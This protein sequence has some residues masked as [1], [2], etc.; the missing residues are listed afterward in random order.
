M[1]QI[2]STPD[3]VLTN[4]N[5]NTQILENT[6]SNIQNQPVN[7]NPKSRA[8]PKLSPV[9]PTKNPA[10]TVVAQN[11]LPF[12]NVETLAGMPKAGSR[13]ISENGKLAVGQFKWR[14]SGK[15]KS[16]PIRVFS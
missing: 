1:P 6:N 8:L 16:R 13:P 4:P 10:E 7:K 11:D 14:I 12:W 2:I 3:E 9:E 15:S 5:T